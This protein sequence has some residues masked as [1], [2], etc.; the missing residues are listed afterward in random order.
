VAD[1]KS[2]GTD[3]R[4]RRAENSKAFGE[5]RYS[6]LGAFEEIAMNSAW[7]QLNSGSSSAHPFVL[8]SS[9]HKKPKN[10]QHD[11]TGNRHG[12]DAINHI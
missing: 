9:H 8:C 5:R 4:L 10:P 7:V 2:V 11:E 12:E 6:D 3:I 1:S